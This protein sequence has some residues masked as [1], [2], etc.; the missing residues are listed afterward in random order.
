MGR[1]GNFTVENI[2]LLVDEWCAPALPSGWGT[3]FQK[4]KI[5]MLL[6]DT[7]RLSASAKY[8]Y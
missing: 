3:Y 5:R 7:C 4:E 2:D 1:E 6:G 8:V